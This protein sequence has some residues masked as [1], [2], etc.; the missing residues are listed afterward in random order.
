MVEEM[1]VARVIGDEIA[2]QRGLPNGKMDLTPW[3]VRDVR[4]GTF[5]GHIR[6]FR[7]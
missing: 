5:V 6:M 4:G 7:M 3:P 2:R 1:D